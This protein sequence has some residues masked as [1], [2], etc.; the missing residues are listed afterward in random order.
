MQVLEER[1]GRHEAAAR[2]QDATALAKRLCRVGHVLQHLGDLDR[3]E[4]GV[5][6]RERLNVGAY[7]GTPGWRH[8]RDDPVRAGRGPEAA[9]PTAAA[10]VQ[11]PTGEPTLHRF[12]VGVDESSTVGG[13][14]IDREARRHAGLRA[15][16]A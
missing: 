6:E 12:E 9:A 16:A 10:D 3:V 1:R 5:A 4:R 7:V 8:V 15:A 13:P 11:N 14:E 2:T